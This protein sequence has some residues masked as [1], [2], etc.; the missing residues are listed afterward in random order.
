MAFYIVT[1]THGNLD[2]WTR[3]LQ[4]HIVFLREILEE[5][6]LRA[7]GPLTDASVKTGFLIIKAND[8]PHVEAIIARDPFAK[9]GL[10]DDLTIQVWDP[11]FGA[12]ASESSGAIPR[13]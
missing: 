10:I 1:M 4:P 5:G 6:V 7:S 12:F 13:D 8:R 2:G 3:H 9:E 11:L